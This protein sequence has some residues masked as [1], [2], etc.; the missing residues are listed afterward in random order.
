M[1]VNQELTCPI[2]QGTKFET[3]EMSTS[4]DKD[5]VRFRVR[6]SFITSD[7]ED[8]YAQKCSKCGYILLFAK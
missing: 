4:H 1:A 3:G 2:C 7:W 8:V 5:A 6:T